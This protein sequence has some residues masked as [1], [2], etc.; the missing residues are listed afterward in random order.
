MNT[1]QS[2][3]DKI[4]ALMSKTVENGCTEHEALAALDKARAMIDAYEVTAEDLQ[5]SREEKAAIHPARNSR[6]PHQIR[7]SLAMKIAAFCDCRC[8]VDRKGM[9]N[10]VGMTSDTQFAHWLLDNLTWF[11]QLNLSKYL[12]GNIS[13]DEDRKL[14]INGFVG[15]C[16]NRINERLKELTKQPIQVNANALMV[17]KGQ[18]ISDVLR[19]AGINLGKGRR[20][21]RNIDRDAF[22]AGRVVGDKASFGRPVEGQQAIKRLH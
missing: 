2:I 21:S 5:L 8:Y 12:T 20:S 4:K 19:A 13:N 6:D 16:C 1:R 14:M 18:A 22:D 15:G 11:V 7:R 3:L 17:I 9:L 10:F